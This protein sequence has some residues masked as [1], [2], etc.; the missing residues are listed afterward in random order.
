MLGGDGAAARLRDCRQWQLNA[1][2][3]EQP[4]GFRCSAGL[5][6]QEGI[7]AEGHIIR[8][9]PSR[10]ALVIPLLAMLSPICGH[11]S[12]QWLKVPDKGIPRTKDGKP[13]LTAP[14]PH[15][16]GGKP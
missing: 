1:A 5:A 16:A 12:E 2:G 13:D 11:L 3:K 8:P 15:K 4:R 10:S 14:A 6:G 9:M 7:A